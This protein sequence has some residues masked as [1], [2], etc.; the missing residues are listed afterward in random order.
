MM[1]QTLFVIPSALLLTACGGGNVVMNTINLSEAPAGSVQV[2]SGDTVDAS[3]LDEL[4]AIDLESSEVGSVIQVTEGDLAGIEIEVAEDT[5]GYTTLNLSGTNGDGAGNASLL[6]TNNPELFIKAQ[7]NLANVEGE[8]VAQHSKL[9]NGTEVTNFE[10]VRESGSTFISEGGLLIGSGSGGIV[11]QINQVAI[12]MEA[13]GSLGYS[14]I[15]EDAYVPQTSGTYIFEGPTVVFADENSY[16]DGTSTMVLNFSE[17]TGTYQANN[18]DPDMDAPD[19]N[20]VI[21]SDLSIDN[22]DGSISGAGGTLVA[23]GN[24]AELS[25]VGILSVNNDAAAG[26]VIVNEATN[27]TEIFGGL[28][29]LPKKP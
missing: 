3:S 17:L 8:T 28:F 16:T 5:E 25:M 26:A 20:I 18:F 15:S 23:G 6:V 10:N 11:A 2:K 9:F 1:K 19:L 14:R 24:T 29:A 22:T 12:G 13:A 7:S 27:Q 21:S 4:L